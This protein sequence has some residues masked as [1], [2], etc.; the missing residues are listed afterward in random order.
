MRTEA[1]F[2]G[3]GEFANR[4]FTLEH[5]GAM[6]VFLLHEGELMARFSQLG[7]TEASLQHE[8]AAHLVKQHH[9]DGCLWKSDS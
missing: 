9:W 8:C 7:A 6:A 2:Q 4:G 3:L 5:D 1:Q